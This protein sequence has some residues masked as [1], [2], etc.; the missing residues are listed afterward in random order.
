MSKI[1]FVLAILAIG[2][3]MA[4]RLMS[5]GAMS[6]DEA[7]RVLGVSADA[8]RDAINAAHRHLIAKVHPDSGGN[9]EL[10]SRVNTARDVLLRRFQ[11]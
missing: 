6:A 2:Y 3:L 4:Q 10:A 11:P 8:D 1:L 5:S 9:N 7:C